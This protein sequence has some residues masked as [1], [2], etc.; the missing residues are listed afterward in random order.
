MGKVFAR[1]DL[2]KFQYTPVAA[3]A[4]PGIDP[5][6]LMIAAIWSIPVERLLEHLRLTTGR[7]RFVWIKEDYQYQISHA[8]RTSADD[9]PK[10]CRFFCLIDHPG[11]P[12]SSHS[13]VMSS[14]NP[15][16]DMRDQLVAE[17]P[18]SPS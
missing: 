18:A 6:C 9:L 13:A 5:F 17:V 12:M 14:R 8:R 1:N 2:P 3:V 4:K 16:R 7:S 11:L 10:P 15:R